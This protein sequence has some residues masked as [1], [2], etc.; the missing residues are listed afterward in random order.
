MPASHATVEEVLA[1][2]RKH[3]SDDIMTELF[4]HLLRIR[5]SRSF[6]ETIRRLRAAHMQDVKKRSMN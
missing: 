4:D 2:V 6:V 3:V 5:G 1:I